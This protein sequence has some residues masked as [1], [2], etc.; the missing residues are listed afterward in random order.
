MGKIH[1]ALNALAGG[2]PSPGPLKVVWGVYDG[3]RC[4][5]WTGCR[6]KS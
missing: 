6:P 5:T 2:K 1:E 4:A 3:P